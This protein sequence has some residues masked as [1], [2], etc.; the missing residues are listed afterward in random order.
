MVY[1][2]V[3]I[4][5]DVSDVPETELDGEVDF[6]ESVALASA[7]EPVYGMGGML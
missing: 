6:A 5:S 4:E 1:G 7:A 3:G 2:A